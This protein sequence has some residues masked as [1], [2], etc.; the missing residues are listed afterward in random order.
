MTWQTACWILKYHFKHVTHS[1]KAFRAN[2][3]SAG[4]KDQRRGSFSSVQWETDIENRLMDMG[5]GQER[6]RCMERGHWSGKETVC[7]VM[8]YRTSDRYVNHLT[9]A[10]SENRPLEVLSGTSLLVLKWF[11]GHKS[12]LVFTKE[13]YKNF[14]NLVLFWP[15]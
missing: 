12:S 10:S 7:H 15:S 6:V 8:S 3:L 11:L 9:L 5:R 14:R 2:S 4:N 13:A 1:M